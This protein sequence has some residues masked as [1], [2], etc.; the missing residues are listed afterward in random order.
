LSA[1]VAAGALLTADPQPESGMRLNA[2]PQAEI[3]DNRYAMR[4]ILKGGFV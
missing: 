3:D 4:M 2:K 1:E